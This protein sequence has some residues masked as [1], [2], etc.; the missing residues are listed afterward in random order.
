MRV[1]RVRPSTR[2]VNRWRRF[3]LVLSVDTL[4]R[5]AK[6]EPARSE[7]FLRLWFRERRDLAVISRK[8]PENPD[9]AGLPAE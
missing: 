6:A 2:D 8:A 5:L 3:V 4:A 9:G 7:E 1:R